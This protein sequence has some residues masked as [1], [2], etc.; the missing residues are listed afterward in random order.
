M[1][2]E[3]IDIEKFLPQDVETDVPV[4]A[5]GTATIELNAYGL[6]DARSLDE[7]W[8]VPDKPGIGE[9]GDRA[10]LTTARLKGTVIESLQ[11]LL[12]DADFTAKIGQ[13][14]SGV[15]NADDAK[16]LIQDLIGSKN[17]PGIKVLS[18]SDM[19]GASG[20]FDDL[21]NTI[22][23]SREFLANNAIAPE[24]V[25]PVFL[26]E[27][28][29]SLDSQLNPEDSPGDEGK[30]FAAI[31][32]GKDLTP[33]ELAILKAENDT[34]TITVNGKEISVELSAPDFNSDSKTDILW[35]NYTTGTN[36][37]WQMDGTNHTNT[38]TLNSVTDSNW[39]IQGTGDIDG[40]GNDDILWRNSANGINTWWQMENGNYITGVLLP[41]VANLDWQIG[42]TG[43]FDGGG[44]VDDI[45]WYNPT[46]G[47]TTIWQMNGA[48][49][50]LGV[51]LP[52]QKEPNWSIGG[53][54]DFNSDGSADILWHNS[55]TG[56]SRAW[57]MNGTNFNLEVAL[58]QQTN[59][60]W[61]FSGSVDL[62]NDG[63]SDLLWRN[64]STGDNR[65]WLMNGATLSSEVNLQSEAD[66]NWEIAL[67]D[68][69]IDN[70]GGG[71]GALPASISSNTIKFSPGD[72]E[73]T[74]AAKGGAK[75]ALGTQTIYIGTWQKSSNNQDPIIASFDS[76]N[77]TNNWT[78]TD[79]EATGA[80]GRGFGL[81]WDGSNLFGVFSVD[82]TQ[83]GPGQD[84]RR[85]TEAA[86]PY[87]WL[88][89]Y[90]SGGGK[91]VSVIARIDPAT[92]E[93]TDAAYLSAR[94]ENGNSNTLRVTDV[95]V[96]GSGNLVVSA[97]SFF[98]PRNPNGTRMT[99]V[100]T[101]SSPF[102]YTVELTPDL[103]TVVS[104]SAVGWVA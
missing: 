38:L 82:G 47:T 28:G 18:A 77:P 1:I 44:K 98:S 67:F 42:G 93:M 97:N 13:A 104:T 12:E 61:Q 59:S 22:Y 51:R 91:K 32:L 76:A 27:I 21:T 71:S 15:G 33:E 45:I 80:D 52:D 69:P 14:F 56:E 16:R 41:R 54:G 24:N 60:N 20:A 40:D 39:R 35:R 57:L 75:I 4:I 85:A 86:S 81:F 36:Q 6:P 84:F 49:Y 83:G 63:N 29:H 101:A 100:V 43:D 10:S 92:G 102:D 96:N 7:F 31:A 26:E 30:I 70:S 53:T 66:S 9:S 73:A 50:Q 25:V 72:D 74:I 58:P 37:I 89:S 78:K 68:N 19:N 79:Y 95:S 99:Q 62:N 88:N 64:Y 65:V 8:G 11:N 87:G 94:L 3:G 23:L 48:T 2:E 103:D 5:G 90:G 46:N 34:G 55:S 17:V